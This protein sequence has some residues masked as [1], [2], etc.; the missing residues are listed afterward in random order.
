MTIFPSVYVIQ[1]VTNKCTTLSI[2]NRLLR[3]LKTILFSIKFSQNHAGSTL[4]IKSLVVE[5]PLHVSAV[6]LLYF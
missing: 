2:T 5:A 6:L 3:E 4:K 1:T